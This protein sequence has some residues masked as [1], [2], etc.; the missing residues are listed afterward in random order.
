MHNEE[1]NENVY[2]ENEEDVRKEEEVHFETTSIPFLDQVLTQQLTFL[3]RL[4]GLGILPIVQ[5]TQ[6]PFNPNIIDIVPKV[7]GAV[8]TNAFYVL[9]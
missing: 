5:A 4:V 1:I 2:V 3:T 9:C 8:G 7:A 6:T